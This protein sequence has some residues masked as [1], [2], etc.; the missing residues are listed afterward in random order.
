MTEPVFIAA[1]MSFVHSTGASRP[2]MSAVV[3]TMSISG[4]SARNF[5]SCFA[6]NSGLDG[7]A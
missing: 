6:R 5:S 4:A 3:M 2:G 7:A 1:T